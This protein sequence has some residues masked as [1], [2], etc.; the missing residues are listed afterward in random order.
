MIIMEKI[1]EELKNWNWLSSNTK[2][3]LIEKKK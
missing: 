2:K 1:S 3:E